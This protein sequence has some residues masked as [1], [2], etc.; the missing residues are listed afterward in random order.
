[1]EEEENPKKYAL[2][3]SAESNA[4]G[5]VDDETERDE[6]RESEEDDEGEEDEE[7]LQAHNRDDDAYGIL[8]RSMEDEEVLDNTQDLTA[9]GNH[10]LET[11]QINEA[12]DSYRGAVRNAKEK[13]EDDTSVRV[14]LGD[15]YAYSGQGLNAF[16]QYKKAIKTSPRKAEPHFALAELYH[17]YG[18][19]QNAIVEY[20]K[21]ISF[22]PLN[23][24]YRYKLGDALAMADE[25]EPAIEEMEQAVSI[26]PEDGFYHFWLGDLYSRA[27]RYE[28]AIREMQQ[29]TIFAPYD[30]YYNARLSVLYRR[31]ENLP[32][33]IEALNLALNISPDNAAYH[34]LIADFYSE[35]HLNEEAIKHY[36]IAGPLDEYDQDLL[37]RLRRFAGTHQDLEMLALEALDEDFNPEEYAF[38]PEE[39]KWED[40]KEFESTEN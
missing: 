2:E 4:E 14:N 7:A 10:R 24:Y 38:D 9:Q 17:K 21:A 16:R 25:L 15:A 5:D 35:S 11:G 37:E 13:G 3:L 23:A 18:R 8:A 33:A 22:A 26:K 36:Q 12:L 30:A 27:V 1:M 31:A 39:F 40:F 28:E 34:C 19:L 32:D 20:R 6:D 29:A